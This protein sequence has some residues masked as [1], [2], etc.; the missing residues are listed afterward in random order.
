[1]EGGWKVDGTVTDCTD[2]REVHTPI[3]SAS[4][5]LRFMTIPPSCAT[6][7]APSPDDSWICFSNF[8]VVSTASRT[9]RTLSATSRFTSASSVSF[10]IRG[11]AIRAGHAHNVWFR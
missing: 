11:S 3:T 10:L 9:V 6:T 2:A 7:G 1:M 4:L 8:S 5:R